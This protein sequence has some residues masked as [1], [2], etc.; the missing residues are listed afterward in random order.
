MRAFNR[1]IYKHQRENICTNAASASCQDTF[2]QKVFRRCAH[3][4]SSHVCRVTENFWLLLMLVKKHRTLLENITILQRV[5]S[6]YFLHLQAAIQEQAQL[7][8]FIGLF[9]CFV[10]WYK[11]C[12]YL[13][14]EINNFY[15]VCS[16][17]KLTFTCFIECFE[18]AANCT[19]TL[20][21]VLFYCQGF[22]LDPNICML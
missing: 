3:E 6:W 16:L 8:F 20:T 21:E 1:H 2:I 15:S 22:S 4:Y 17:N 14:L 19:H 10:L 18:Y 12:F 13:L 5:K 9:L 7:L 11:D